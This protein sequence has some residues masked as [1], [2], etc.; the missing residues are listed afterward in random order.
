MPSW[1]ELLVPEANYRDKPEVAANAFYAFGKL[2]AIGFAPFSIESI[3]E[4]QP[5]PV[6]RA[7]AVLAQLS[8]TILTNQG[9]GRMSGFRPRV[10][11]DETVI[12]LP[13][14]ETI[15]NYRFSVSFHD[16]EVPKAQQPVREGPP[17]A[18]IDSAWEGS[19]DAK[20]EWLPLCLKRPAA[21][22]ADTN[23]PWRASPEGARSAPRALSVAQRA[24]RHSTLDYTGC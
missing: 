7:Y 1:L 9:F 23:S 14:T 11:E 22:C 4:K 21:G 10:L 2:D 20:G 24:R 18:G 5:N 12:T 17:L 15:G 6:A 19:F 13:V 3:D 8:S 16:T